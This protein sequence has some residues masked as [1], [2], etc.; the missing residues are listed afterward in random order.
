MAGGGGDDKA[1]RQANVFLCSF[2]KNSKKFHINYM[3]R[4]NTKLTSV[5]VSFFFF[6]APKSSEIN[7]SVTYKKK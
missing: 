5:S 2:A 6:C 3:Q 1:A 4:G 7:F